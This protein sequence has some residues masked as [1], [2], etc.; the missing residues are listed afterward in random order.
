MAVPL[1][2]SVSV[3]GIGEFTFKRRTLDAQFKIE[4]GAVQLL[5]GETASDALYRMAI[6]FATVRHLAVT[7]P[8]GWDVDEIDPL[9][10]EQMDRVQRVFGRLRQQEETFRKGAK[11]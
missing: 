5:G 9:D 3:D 1:T 7:V 8:E 4:A 10:S 6:S 2:F 11:P